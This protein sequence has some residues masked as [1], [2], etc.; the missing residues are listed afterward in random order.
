MSIVI[1]ILIS[2]LQLVPISIGSASLG[3]R[4]LREPRDW[5]ISGDNQSDP[6]CASAC[7]YITYSTL[8]CNLHNIVAIRR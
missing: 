5:G 1:I 2:I 3:L 6:M 7:K 4:S 8:N